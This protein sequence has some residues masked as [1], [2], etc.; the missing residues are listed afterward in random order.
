M[1]YFYF[2]AVTAV[3]QVRQT[4]PLE[5]RMH[6]LFVDQIRIHSTIGL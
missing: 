2:S 4:L 1:V 3:C 5:W 6:A